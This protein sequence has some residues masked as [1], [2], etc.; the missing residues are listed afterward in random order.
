MALGDF[1]LTKNPPVPSFRTEL[2]LDDTPY[3]T[4]NSFKNKEALAQTIQNLLVL[5]K[6][7]MPNDPD[8][9][10][11]IS[12]YVFELED[13][14]TMRELESIIKDQIGK[15][16]THYL[17]HVDV[18]VEKYSDPGTPNKVHTVLIQIDITDDQFVDPAKNTNSLIYAVA[19]NKVTKKTITELI[20]H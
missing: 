17:L 14:E 8:M 6:G 4:E 1:R 7:N 15:Y 18:N 9:G 19:A 20:Y 10:V 5:H 2:L 13:L 12:D 11:G 3:Q 16:I